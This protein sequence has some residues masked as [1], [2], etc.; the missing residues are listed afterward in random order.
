MG[1]ARRRHPA[2][3]R[4]DEYGAD[5]LAAETALRAAAAADPAWRVLALRLPD[6]LGPHENTGRLNKLLLRLAK[7]KPIGSAIDGRAGL[8]AT[9]P[10]SCVGA[11][12][13][14]FGGECLFSK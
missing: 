1:G 12:D 9:L 6:V 8:G 14:A 2:R 13:V 4:D 10:L 5:K 11:D 7:G 3:A